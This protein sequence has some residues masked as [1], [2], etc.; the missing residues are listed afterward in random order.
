M[1]NSHFSFFIV[2]GCLN[3]FTVIMQLFCDVKTIK[4]KREKSPRSLKIA[5]LYQ[6]SLVFLLLLFFYW[7]WFFKYSNENRFMQKLGTVKF[8]P[9]CND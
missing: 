3:V 4:E 5:V 7:F 9:F 1:R 2:T 6:A 8:R